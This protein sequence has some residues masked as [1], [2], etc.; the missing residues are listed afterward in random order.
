MIN[1]LSLFL[2]CNINSSN[3]VSTSN[4]RLSQHV[5]P[6]NSQQGHYTGTFYQYEIVDDH[7]NTKY[8]YINSKSQTTKKPQTTITIDPTIIDIKS[9]SNS[10]QQVLSTA[11]ETSTPLLLPSLNYSSFSNSNTASPETAS[12]NYGSDS[13]SSTSKGILL[14]FDTSTSAYLRSLN[15][16]SSSYSIPFQPA[17]I[18]KTSV[19]VINSNSTSSICLNGSPMETSTRNSSQTISLLSDPSTSSDSSMLSDNT[20]SSSPIPVSRMLPAPTN[21]PEHETSLSRTQTINDKLRSRCRKYHKL[22]KVNHSIPQQSTTSIKLCTTRNKKLLSMT[23][24]KQYSC[25]S[26]KL[27]FQTAYN[28]NVHTD[29]QHVGIKFPCDVCKSVCKYY[30]SLRDHMV[31]QHNVRHVLPR[32]QLR[33]EWITGT[34]IRR[35]AFIVKKEKLGHPAVWSC[36]ICGKRTSNSKDIR[37]CIYKHYKMLHFGFLRHCHAAFAKLSD[38]RQNEL[39][40]IIQRLC[41]GVRRSSK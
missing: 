5:R 21:T 32:K 28:R 41:Y 18:T 10:T 15:T 22:V 2:I 17:E 34:R 40:L 23:A 37:P 35:R 9:S 30:S 20:T 1:Q 33:M 19:K 13:N 7:G 16:N 3:R 14:N 6:R 38:G 24:D 31:K 4:Q 36:E 39:M 11:S 25:Q 26:C 12:S 27:V 29:A 8:F